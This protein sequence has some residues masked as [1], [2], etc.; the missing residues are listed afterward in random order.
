M[1]EDVSI[2]KALKDSNILNIHADLTNL[3]WLSDEE[4]Q[5]VIPKLVEQ[6]SIARENGITS[7][8]LHAPSGWMWGPETEDETERQKMINRFV[9]LSGFVKTAGI[10][11]IVVHVNGCGFPAGGDKESGI[12]RV[13]RSLAELRDKCEVKLLVENMPREELG[14]SSA[15]MLRI[16]DGLDMDSVCDVNH[17]FK[18]PIYSYMTA[19]GERIKA[20]H[21]SDNDGINEAHR[22]PGKGVINWQEVIKALK[23]INYTGTLNFET[24]VKTVEDIKETRIVANAIFK[25][26]L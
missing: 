18:E 3:V 21:I 6:V 4:Q 1:L 25:E 5:A 14:N 23:D 8:V 17:V 19:L 7:D 9:R 15:E 11:Y 24:H 2:I 20:L 16:L 13:R 22:M 12:K 10:P 26:L